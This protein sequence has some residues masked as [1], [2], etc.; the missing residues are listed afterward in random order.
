V[1]GYGL[2]WAE[3]FRNLKAIYRVEGEKLH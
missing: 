3:K 1:V 2:D